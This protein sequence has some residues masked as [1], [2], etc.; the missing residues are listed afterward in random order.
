MS[1][2]DITFSVPVADYQ[3]LLEYKETNTA[4]ENAIMIMM[5]AQCLEIF[6]T[7]RQN[8]GNETL[9]ENI[10]TLEARIAF[11]KQH[12]ELS[13]AEFEERLDLQA[14]RKA[15]EKIGA[16]DQYISDLRNVINHQLLEIA[17][18]RAN[19]EVAGTNASLSMIH[20]ET[21]R[22]LDVF[23]GH[24][25]RLNA[26]TDEIIRARQSNCPSFQNPGDHFQY[27]ASRAF[28]D[29]FH[30]TPLYNFDTNVGKLTFPEFAL[31]FEVFN[32]E[33]SISQAMQEEFLRH[34]KQMDLQIGWLISLKSSFVGHDEYP[35]AIEWVPFV[36]E[37]E[38]H[39]LRFVLYI[40]TVDSFTPTDKYLKMAYNYTATLVTFL[41]TSPNIV[42]EMTH[43][44]FEKRVLDALKQLSDLA[45]E[46]GNM[47]LDL[48]NKI[49]AIKETNR[50]TKELIHNTL[51]E[52]TQ[53]LL[54]NSI[55]IEDKKLVKIRSWLHTVIK[56][57]SD[58]TF[59][60]TFNELWEKFKGSNKLGMPL[61]RKKEMIPI[62][63]HILHEFMVP[64]SEINPM[65]TKHVW[66]SQKPNQDILESSHES[67][68]DT[69]R[70]HCIPNPQ[71]SAYNRMTAR[72]VRRLNGA[73]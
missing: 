48:N 31:S 3:K 11:L 41:K 16:K 14:D 20:S 6:R 5:G 17:N 67:E 46:E 23:D 61:M 57:D 55:F 52:K 69:S 39:Q 28:G 59:Y 49:L 35:I 45:M 64:G 38:H 70:I 13:L 51:N 56:Q 54:M 9:Q 4:E 62:L 32:T 73:K 65:F 42:E 19:V 8:I 12:Y 72:P 21:Q 53:D 37:D 30:F 1:V 71:N 26:T 44:V 7:N 29:T 43:K 60:I 33:T 22:R 24:L 25:E 36:D 58:A 66:I 10:R 2:C 18:Y 50:R 68:S 27:V 15:E 40:N 63:T 47:I 34:F